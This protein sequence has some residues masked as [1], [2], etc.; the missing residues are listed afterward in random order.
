MTTFSS[1]SDAITSMWRQS[2]PPIHVATFDSDYNLAVEQ[3][4]PRLH[5]IGFQP[6]NPSQNPNS[7]RF[8]KE[9]PYHCFIDSYDIGQECVTREFRQTRSATPVV[10]SVP[11]DIRRWN[12]NVPATTLTESHYR[13]SWIDLFSSLYSENADRRKLSLRV[14]FGYRQRIEVLCNDGDLDGITINKASIQDFWSFVE[15]VPFASKAE[16][17]LVENG[18]LRAVWDGE[19]GSHLGFQFLGD[20]MVQ[21]VIFRRRHGSGHVSRVAGRDTLEGVKKQVRNFD[22]EALLKA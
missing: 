11:Q 19:D 1:T 6:W 7:N 10:D 14:L 5:N 8:T 3:N 15:S 22:L 21:Y 2:K 13:A 20:H 18:N 16:I 9:I 4:Q 12:P 17:V